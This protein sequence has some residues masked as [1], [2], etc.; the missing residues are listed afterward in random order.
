[1]CHVGS[2]A[3]DPRL[4]NLIFRL[5][6]SNPL[7]FACGMLSSLSYILT[8][9]IFL[10][11]PVPRRCHVPLTGNPRLSNL[12]FRLPVSNDLG[13]C[14]RSQGMFTYLCCLLCS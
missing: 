2:P 6:V 1:M 7:S 8:S 4:R 11:P 9:N 12:I 5:P 10:S 3:G 13:F 14:S